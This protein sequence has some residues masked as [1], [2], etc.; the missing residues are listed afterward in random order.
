MIG[1][2]HAGHISVALEDAAINE[3]WN[4]IYIANRIESIDLDSSSKFSN[5]VLNT[6]PDLVIISQYWKSD[7]PYS[8][9]KNN[10]LKMKEF[11]PKILLIENNPIWP[12]SAR[13]TLSG[14]LIAPY[15]FPKSFQK[16]ELDITDRYASDEI[17][18]FATTQ[19]ISTLNFESLFCSGN[20]CTRYSKNGW[21]YNDYNHMSLAG[22]ALTVPQLTAVLNKS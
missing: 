4:S 10:I 11:S 16:S 9:I 21:L 15:K 3:N 13:F 12:D 17:S 18:K 7:S 2:S 6:S 5:W 22:A 14:Y 20:I 1:D 19:G 8:N